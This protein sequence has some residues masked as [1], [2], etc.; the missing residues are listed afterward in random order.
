MS[1]RTPEE[2]AEQRERERLVDEVEHALKASLGTWRDLAVIAVS[3]VWRAERCM[4][5]GS[6]LVP[7]TLCSECASKNNGE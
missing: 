6:G 4:R 2:M 5:C 3:T 7:P 1:S